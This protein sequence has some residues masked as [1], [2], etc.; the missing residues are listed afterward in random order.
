MIA[1]QKAGLFGQVEAV[2]FVYGANV[3]S[4]V[5]TYMLASGLTGVAR[6]VALYLVGFNFVAAFLLVPLLYFE[7]WAEVPLVLALVQRHRLPS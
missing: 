5:L 4:S 6:Q 1:F 2:M 7:L 3:G